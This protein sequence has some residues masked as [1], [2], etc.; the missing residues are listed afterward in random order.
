[1]A[2]KA[3]DHFLDGRRIDV[4]QCLLREEISGETEDKKNLKHMS[5]KSSAKF[6]SNFNLASNSMLESEK[7]DGD[8]ASIKSLKQVSK[9]HSNSNKSGLARPVQ[10]SASNLPNHI[11][12][13]H[14]PTG[15]PS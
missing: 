7:N 9:G 10:Y 2:L 8:V 6:N 13:C 1:M 5:T 11:K 14:N 4:Q 3:N 15:Y 12:L